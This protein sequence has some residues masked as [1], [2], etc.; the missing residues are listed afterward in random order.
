MLFGKYGSHSD[1]IGLV[2]PGYTHGVSISRTIPRYSNSREHILNIPK[3]RNE[4]HTMG[5][6]CNGECV[7]TG[8]ELHCRALLVP[9]LSAL[10]KRF[11]KISDAVRYEEYPSCRG[12]TINE[13]RGSYFVPTS[14]VKTEVRHKLELF[15]SLEFEN[16]SESDSANASSLLSSISKERVRTSSPPRKSLSVSGGVWM[17]SDDRSPWSLPN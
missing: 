15:N 13:Q 4:D 16:E 8:V 9:S 2:Y 11:I 7:D 3:C 17:S 12:Y 14:G 5:C 6:D 1:A 10:K